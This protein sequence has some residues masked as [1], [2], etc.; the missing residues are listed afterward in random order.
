[1]KKR[2]FTLVSFL[3]FFLS[4]LDSNASHFRFGHISWTRTPGTRTV[5][6]TITT[7]WRYDATESINFDFGDGSSTGSGLLGTEILYVPNEYR[8][9]QL[10]LSHTYSTDGPFTASFYD[11]CRISNLQNGP[12][13]DYAV[14]SI[15]CLANNNLGSPY[16]AP[17]SP[18]MI[19]MTAGTLN[20]FQ[21]ATTEPDG[22]TI[23]YSTTAIQGNNFIPTIGGNIASVSATGLVSWNTTGATAGQLYQ[24]KVIMSDGCA[25]SEIDFI[26]K[27]VAP[28]LPTQLLAC[29]KFDGNALDSKGSNHGTVNGATL[30]TDRFGKAN[31][32]YSFN[33][34]SNYISIPGA[35]LAPNQYTY[36]AWVNASNTTAYS[37]TIISIGGNG[38]DQAVALTNVT[39]SNPNWNFFSYI[40]YA[41]LPIPQVLSTNNVTTNQWH[42]VVATRT[43]NNLTLYIDG[44]KVGTVSSTGVAPAYATPI[45]GAIGSRYRADIQFFTGKIDD[46]KIYVGALTEEEVSL[47][48]NEEQGECSSPCSGMIYSLASGDWNTPA[49]WSCGRVPNL[50]DKVLIKSGH[51]ITISTNN[52]NAKK[53]L[54][55]GRVSFANTTGRLTFSTN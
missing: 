26:I 33:G 12:D 10:Q 14:S 47:L 24:M 1:M 19:E 43:V 15:V 25:K 52:A 32:A 27:I 29:Y 49:T 51:N 21:L 50:S 41:A 40:Y 23:S 46:V 36:A 35:S 42:F 6:F 11:C 5:N 39:A 28:I 55:S 9:F 20:Q 44:K 3:I 22:S 16:Y 18:V 48:Y 8:V 13:A 34:I 54:N 4:A 2:I 38:S 30:T 17:T 37:Q 53:L 31:S 45:A 7:A